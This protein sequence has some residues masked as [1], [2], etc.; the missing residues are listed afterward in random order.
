MM[1]LSRIPL[2]DPKIKIIYLTDVA[3]VVMP[4]KGSAAFWF[5]LD[6]KGNYFLLFLKVPPPPPARPPQKIQSTRCTVV[7]FR[8][9]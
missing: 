5:D 8:D 9:I 7:N 1:T 2:I 4:T 3:K 6:A